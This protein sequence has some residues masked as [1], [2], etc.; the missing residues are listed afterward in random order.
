MATAALLAQLVRTWT[1]EQGGVDPN[2][3]SPQINIILA[4]LNTLP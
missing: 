4:M 3:T 1:T 2:Q